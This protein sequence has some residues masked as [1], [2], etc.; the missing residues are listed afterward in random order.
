MTKAKEAL[1]AL[2]EGRILFRGD[3]VGKTYE[4]EETIRKALKLLNKVESGYSTDVSIHYMTEND[5]SGFNVNDR[6]IYNMGLNKVADK[7]ILIERE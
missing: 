3:T 5:N 2:N 7:Y 6:V 1:D 4:I